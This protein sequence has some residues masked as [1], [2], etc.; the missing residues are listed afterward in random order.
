MWPI[1]IWPLLY[2]NTR[3]SYH[4][5]HARCNVMH[6]KCTVSVRGSNPPHTVNSPLQPTRRT[7]TEP[8][9]EN[10]DSQCVQKYLVSSRIPHEYATHIRTRSGSREILYLIVLCECNAGRQR[11]HGADCCPSLVASLNCSLQPTRT[12]S[13]EHAR[14]IARAHGTLTVHSIYLHSFYPIIHI[15]PRTI[16][17]QGRYTLRPI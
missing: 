5:K 6:R 17:P 13:L 8:C 15:C 1:T 4:Y 11:G 3:D 10:P 7:T 12:L 9:N 14:R 16:V 2:I